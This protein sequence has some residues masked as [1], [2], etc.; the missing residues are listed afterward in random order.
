[1]SNV[2]KRLLSKKKVSEIFFPYYTY[3]RKKFTFWLVCCVA[4][5]IPLLF[6]LLEGVLRRSKVGRREVRRTTQQWFCRQNEVD[7]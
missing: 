3:V 7:R 6:S 4:Y 1:M 5:F 2:F